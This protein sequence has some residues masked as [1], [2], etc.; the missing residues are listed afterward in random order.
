M[1]IAEEKTLEIRKNAEANYNKENH[2]A[3]LTNEYIRNVI[4]KIVAN[5]EKEHSF[6]YFETMVFSTWGYSQNMLYADGSLPRLPYA[7]QEYNEEQADDY[8][9]RHKHYLL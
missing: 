9:N 6:V 4:N 3:A 1:K 2:I 8:C 5:V 7:C